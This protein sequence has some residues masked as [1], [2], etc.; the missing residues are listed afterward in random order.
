MKLLKPDNEPSHHT[1]LELFAKKP[2][3]VGLSEIF[4]FFLSVSL[5][6]SPGE[7]CQK[8]LFFT[9]GAFFW[10]LSSQKEANLPKL[11]F[12]K[13]STLLAFA[14]KDKLWL[15][16]LIFQLKFLEDKNVSLSLTP[17]CFVPLIVSPPPSF[18]FNCY[19]F[20]VL[21]FGGK[22]LL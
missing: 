19:M 20:L 18:L 14:P 13:S 11:F 12:A 9:I 15:S 17:T 1:T 6:H 2:Q 22:K 16:K 7:F 10:A 3:L 4:D 8:T 5:T 21:Y